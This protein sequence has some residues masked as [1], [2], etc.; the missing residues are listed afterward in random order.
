MAPAPHRPTHAMAD[1]AAARRRSALYGLDPTTSEIPHLGE[2]RPAGDALRRLSAPVLDRL[3]SQIEDTSLAVVLAD[4]EGRMTH[5]DAATARTLAAMD[6][7]SLD[8]GSSLAES[9]VGT[10]GVGTSLETKRPAMVVGEDLAR[11]CPPGSRQSLVGSLAAAGTRDRRSYRQRTHGALAAPTQR[12][13]TAKRSE[14]NRTLLNGRT[15]RLNHRDSTSA[16][17][18]RTRTLTRRITTRHRPSVRCQVPVPVFQV[19]SGS[20]VTARRRFRGSSRLRG[21]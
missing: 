19:G 8:V 20:C 17:C 21:E 16:R 11:G 6:D 2:P 7:R 3:L 18:H 4:R 14:P 13:L 5:R 9:D 1:M 15:N 12:R 10:N